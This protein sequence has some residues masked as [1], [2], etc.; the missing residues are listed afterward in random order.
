M[1]IRSD[2]LTKLCQSTQGRG[3]S[4]SGIK[5]V[6][7]GGRVIVIDTEAVDLDCEDFALDHL[8]AGEA[9]CLSLQVKFG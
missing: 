4:T 5:A 8:E 9:D 2:F 1:S 3:G 6:T 7:A